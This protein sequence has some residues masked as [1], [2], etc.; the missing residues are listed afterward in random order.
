MILDLLGLWEEDAVQAQPRTSCRNVDIYKQFV[1]NQQQFH[2]KAKEQWQASQKAREANHQSV[3]KPQISHF[4]KEL[5][6]IPGITTTAIPHTSVDTTEESSEE[7]V[8][9][10]EEELYGGNYEELSVSF[11]PTSTDTTPSD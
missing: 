8:D 7:E 1:R 9:E 10:E 6:S 4:Y 3:A 5:H 2:M 11:P